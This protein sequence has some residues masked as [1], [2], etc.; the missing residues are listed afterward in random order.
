MFTFRKKIHTFFQFNNDDFAHFE[1]IMST[2]IG[3]V[4]TRIADGLLKKQRK[5]EKKHI[6]FQ[7]QQ[8][9][10]SSKE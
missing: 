1:T 3:G 5:E 6:T 10:W 7:K 9:R 4:D 2:G 8:R